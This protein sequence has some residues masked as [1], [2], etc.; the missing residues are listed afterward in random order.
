MRCER[1][2]GQRRPG[3]AGPRGRRLHRRA[4]GRSC[5]CSQG[6]N[7]AR[8]PGANHA[9]LTASDAGPAPPDPEAGNGP[10]AAPPCRAPAA[11][12]GS[13]RASRWD[14]CRPGAG[15]ILKYSW[16][17]GQ[18]RLSQLQA[19]GSETDAGRLGT[20]KNR[21]PE[22]RR[23]TPNRSAVRRSAQIRCKSGVNQE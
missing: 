17:T 22:T 21:G 20:K 1:Q 4:R 7:Q 5:R 12:A 23:N 8:V 11:G 14:A 10:A 16:N 6:V 15:Q 19:W 2:S 18:I 9:S 13:P 3:P